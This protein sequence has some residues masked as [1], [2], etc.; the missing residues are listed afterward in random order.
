MKVFSREVQYFLRVGDSSSIQETAYSIGITPAA[1]SL[2]LTRFE[3]QFGKKLLERDRKG[4]RLTTLGKKL[5]QTLLGI[6]ERAMQELDEVM[7]I[8]DE[9]PLR[10]GSVHHVGLKYVLPLLDDTHKKHVYLG[11]SLNVKRL[12]EEAKLDFGFI[13]WTKRPEGVES[14][15]LWG[16]TT[17]VVGLRAKF[18]HIAKARSIK[19]LK[20]ENWIIHPKPQYDPTSF[21]APGATTLIAGHSDPM[22][23]LILQGKGIGVCQIDQFTDS[24][25]AQLTIAKA[26]PQKP[27]VSI[28]AI[29]NRRTPKDRLIQL[30]TLIRQ[31]AKRHT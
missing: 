23:Q 12:V 28:Y 27:K 17:R 26:I 11:Y 31:L 8:Q 6:H 24:E 2:A 4:I 25:L 19:Y 30:Q 3:A 20:N 18:A 15:R 22:K 16:D 10:L 1:L 29:W 21:F 7:H 9:R 5:H 13:G 14:E